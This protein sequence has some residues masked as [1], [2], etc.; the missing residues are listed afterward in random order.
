MLQ[1]QCWLFVATEIAPDRPTHYY[2][3]TTAGHKDRKEVFV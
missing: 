3:T 2:T 1:L